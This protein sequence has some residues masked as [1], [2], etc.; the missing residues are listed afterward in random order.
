MV[1]R[2]VKL[3]PERTIKFKVADYK[4]GV[5]DSGSLFTRETLRGGPVEPR[6][7]VEAYINTNRALFNVKKNFMKDLDA[8]KTLGIS[9]RAYND[10]VDISLRERYA[11]ES[12]EF[13]PYVPS[14]NIQRAFADNA[15]KIGVSN[16]YRSAASTINSIRRELSRLSL[17]SPEFP[18]INNPL[19]PSIMDQR[20]IPDLPSVEAEVGKGTIQNTG[21]VNAASMFPFGGGNIPYNRLT[22]QQKI[23]ILFGQG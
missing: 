20:T 15:S 1:F 21:Q 9:R 22:T 3:N 6:D 14:M 2:A 18:V 19:M 7:I 10:N 11:I 12:G 16:P 23:D 17:D 8:A 5:R 4:R 13:R